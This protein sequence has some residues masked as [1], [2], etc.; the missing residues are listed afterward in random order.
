MT[1]PIR[2]AHGM[3]AQPV[4]ADWPALQQRDVE[5]VLQRFPQLG[6]V[7]QLGW[8]SP[9]PF[10]A[11][12]QVHT[13]RG[14]VFVKRHHRSVREPAWL[15]EEHRFVRYLK[16]RGVPVTPALRDRDGHS[17]L[18]LGEWT[19]EVLPRAAGDD[20]YREALSWTPFLDRHHAHS[21]G[22]ALARL[23]RAAE[24]FYAAPR[25]APVLVA[26]L[27]LFSQPDPLR[28]IEQA[29]LGQP[30][31]ARYL[32]GHDWR[33]ALRE[34]H[35]PFHRQLLPLLAAQ[36]ALWTHNDWHASNLL[37][38]GQGGSAEVESVLDFGLSDRTF[39]LFDLATALERNCIPW[40]EL[41][42]GGRA[43]ADLD[44]VDALLA[45][46]ASQRPLGRHD[47]LTLKALLPLVHADFALNEVDYFE[48]IVGSR[49]SADIAYH[50]FLIGHARWF[51]DSEGAR[52]LDHL[53]R[54]ARTHNN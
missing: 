31:L 17:A 54:L 14:E 32:A 3:G 53:E 7:Q 20:L 2:I 4:E 48:G 34:L 43:T 6:A 8:H 40:L 13:D 25:Q 49:A 52:L 5:Q 16:D 50:A 51:G 42:D 22:D 18:A 11:A 37:W 41:D 27:R 30:A 46:Y 9:R 10:S 23:H 39:A 28:A 15:E 44:A 29:L 47:L 33:H 26:N 35:L 1:Q 38:R 21:A 36:P 24:G 19:Y 45:G 12:A